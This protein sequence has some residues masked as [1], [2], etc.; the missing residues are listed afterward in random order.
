MN[1]DMKIGQKIL[2][3]EGRNEKRKEDMKRGRKK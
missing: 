2:E 3:D 1:Q